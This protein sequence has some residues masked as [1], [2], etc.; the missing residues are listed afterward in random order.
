[1]DIS[2]CIDAIVPKAQYFGSLT[3]NTQESFDNLIW[4]DKR[5]K[6]IWNEIESVWILVQ[7]DLENEIILNRLENTD[8]KISRALEDNVDLLISKGLVSIKDYPKEFQTVYNLKK[9]LRSQIL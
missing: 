3:D 9:E 4:N 7:K 6:P 2:L 5:V 1:M 8:S